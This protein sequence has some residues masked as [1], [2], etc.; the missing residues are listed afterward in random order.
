MRVSVVVPAFNQSD[1][2]RECL[3]SA[4]RQTCDDIEVI[5]VDDGSTDDTR[6]VCEAFGDARLHYIHQAN[7]RTMGIGA[8]N[9]AMLQARG[10]WIA[11][12]DQ[13]DRWAPDKLERQLQRVAQS[14]DAGAVFCR[15]RFIDGS[16]KVTG[17][18]DHGLPEGDVFHQMLTQNRYYAASGIFRRSLL[19][20]I[21]LPHAWVGLGDHVLWLGVTRRTSV[22]VVDE[23]LADYRVHE[24]GYQE[25][26]RRAGL[27]RRADDMWQVALWQAPLLHRGCAL[28]RRAHLRARR[29]SARQYLRALNSNWAVGRFAGSGVPL[30]R[31][32]LAAPSW[33]VQPWVLLREAARL[34]VS[35]V[36]GAL[37]RH[38]PGT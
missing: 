22:V 31:V 10:E 14:P 27:I 38:T 17:E 23:A 29:G 21:G 16:G 9:H 6:A 13:D 11:L 35:A 5:V 12:L 3:H 26:Q 33:L 32:L 18:Q 15:V 20:A 1:Y 4:L 8:R 2:L 28:C 30:G 36:R 19:P 25:A 7:D 37:T 24:Q 34:S